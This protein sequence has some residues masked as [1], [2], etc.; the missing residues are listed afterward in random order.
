MYTSGGTSGFFFLGP[1]LSF[2]QWVLG[3]KIALSLETEK[4]MVT[5]HWATA[6][7]L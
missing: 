7:S 3:L 6:L 5:A 1:R 4:V 2:N